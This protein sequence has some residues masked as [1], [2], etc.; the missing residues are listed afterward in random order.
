MVTWFAKEFD[1]DMQLRTPLVQENTTRRTTR[2][3]NKCP[4]LSRMTPL[5][6]ATKLGDKDMFITVLKL[7]A[8]TQWQWGTVTHVR[9][10]L[11]GI[12][13]SGEQ[14]NDCMELVARLD[15]ELGTQVLRP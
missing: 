9:I 5:Q 10:D 12:D 6:I 2:K 3:E 7:H 15:A 14:G 8:H 11:R 13:S 1:C 4:Q